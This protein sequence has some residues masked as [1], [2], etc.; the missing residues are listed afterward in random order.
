MHEAVSDVLAE[1]VAGADGVSRMILLSLG[2]HAAVIAAVV[3]MPASWRGRGCR[4]K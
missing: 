4:P 2:V 3:L 1:R